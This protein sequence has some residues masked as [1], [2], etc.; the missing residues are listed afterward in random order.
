MLRE[1]ATEDAGVLFRTHG[2]PAADRVWASLKDP[3]KLLDDRRHA[4]LMVVEIERLDRL[5]R[6]AVKSTSLVAW[7]QPFFSLTRLRSLF[8]RGRRR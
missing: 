7:K 4:R 2:A 5:G 1:K 6:Q 3:A 8:R